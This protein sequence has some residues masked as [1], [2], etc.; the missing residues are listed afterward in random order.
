MSRT[1]S[2]FSQKALDKLVD[3]GARMTVTGVSARIL[4]SLLKHSI[5]T[6]SRCVRV[7]I[8]DIKTLQSLPILWDVLSQELAGRSS[9]LDRSHEINEMKEEP[10]LETR[11][12]DCC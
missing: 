1:V 4:M 9:V 7:W 5:R 8:N 10:I 2:V 3:L 6:L 11:I 12:R